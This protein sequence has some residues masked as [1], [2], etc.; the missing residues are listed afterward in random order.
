[1]LIV[2]KFGGTS[3]LDR[4]RILRAARRARA[5]K[6][7]GAQVVV[8]VSAGDILP[9]RSW[10]TWPNFAAHPMPERR[11]CAFLPASNCLPDSWLWH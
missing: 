2:L 1:M 11:I 5:L 6:Q 8:V 10:Q 3:L 7:Q 9:M 4:E